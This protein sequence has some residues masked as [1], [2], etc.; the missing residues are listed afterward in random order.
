MPIWL[1]D[2]IVIEQTYNKQIA[3]EE[4]QSWILRVDLE[5]RNGLVTCSDGNK[6]IVFEKSL[7]FTDFPVAEITLWLEN[8]TVY[9][10][11]ER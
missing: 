6:R 3:R 11:S 1:L 7:E 2:L 9:L 10:P 8:N 5:R 4:F